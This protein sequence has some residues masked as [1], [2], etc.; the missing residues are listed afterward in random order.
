MRISPPHPNA[1]ALLD[2]TDSLFLQG[3]S[4][5]GQFQPATMEHKIDIASGFYMSSPGQL[6]ACSCQMGIYNETA[7]NPDTCLYF[8]SAMHTLYS[9]FHYEHWPGPVVDESYQLQCQNCLVCYPASNPPEFPDHLYCTC[10]PQEQGTT[11]I[12][13]FVLSRTESSSAELEAE[14]VRNSTSTAPYTMSSSSSYSVYDPHGN[15]GSYYDPN[16]VLD[17]SG[18]TGRYGFSELAASSGGQKRHKG[19]RDETN[20]ATLK[21]PGLLGSSRD[22]TE[23]MI[24]KVPQYCQPKMPRRRRFSSITR[25]WQQPP[26]SVA[27]DLPSRSDRASVFRRNLR[28]LT[29]QATMILKAAALIIGPLLLLLVGIG[30]TRETFEPGWQQVIA[31]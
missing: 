31:N 8:A 10:D 30:V 26:G 14:S 19:H 23:P 5:T 13:K 17:Y 15:S 21:K 24:L 29:L 27:D 22:S 12:L 6:W 11:W 20:A 28:Q 4:W 1:I 16:F 9:H 7:P 25:S 3:A 18:G 2:T